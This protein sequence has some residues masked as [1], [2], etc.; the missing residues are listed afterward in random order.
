MDNIDLTYLFF[1]FEGRINRAKL[2]LGLVVV[3]VAE[4]IVGGVAGF[5]STL[6]YLVSL[7]V[8]WPFLAVSVKRW[9]DR[10]KSG[11]W[12]LIGLIPVI[13]WLW[14]LIELGFLLGTEGPNQYGPDPLVGSVPEAA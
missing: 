12:V 4:A 13:G 11:W 14:L 3:W 10:D 2:W 5:T 9:H 1:R 7:A 6:Y 8:L